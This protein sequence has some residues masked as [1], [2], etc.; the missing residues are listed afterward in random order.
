MPLF[1]KKKRD[2]DSNALSNGGSN[3][4]NNGGGNHSRPTSL[5]TTT[6]SGGSFYNNHG[7]K[8]NGGSGARGTPP[9]PYQ[10]PNSPGSPNDLP[11]QKPKLVF[12]C[13]QAQGSPTGIISGF[14]NIRELYQKISDCYDFHPSEVRNILNV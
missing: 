3:D 9:P 14:T 11:V 8:V 13:Q 6:G 10:S 5:D 4:V 2:S 7:A 1:G 12:H